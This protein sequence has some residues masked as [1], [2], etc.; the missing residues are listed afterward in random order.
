MRNEVTLGMRVFDVPEL[1]RTRPPT[2]SEL[3]TAHWGRR[4]DILAVR[5]HLLIGNELRAVALDGILT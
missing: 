2:T 5:Q 3:T 1:Q 4:Q